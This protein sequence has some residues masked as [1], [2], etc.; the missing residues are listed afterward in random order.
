VSGQMPAPDRAYDEP[1]S[2]FVE[3]AFIHIVGWLHDE[4]DV[5]VLCVGGGRYYRYVLP[6]TSKVVRQ[7]FKHLGVKDMALM[8]EGAYDSGIGY[9]PIAFQGLQIGEDDPEVEDGESLPTGVLIGV[10][11]LD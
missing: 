8:P 7:F 3:D 10:R 6:K 5:E 1:L 4:V 2:V 9:G 11:F